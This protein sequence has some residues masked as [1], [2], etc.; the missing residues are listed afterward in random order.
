[1]HNSKSKEKGTSRLGET[2]H[3]IKENKSRQAWRDHNRKHFVGLSWT[4]YSFLPKPVCWIS[5]SKWP[6]SCECMCTNVY[7]NACMCVCIHAC[8]CA[9]MHACVHA[10]VC[11][12]A[13]MNVCAMCSLAGIRP[14]LTPGSLLYFW[15]G[16]DQVKVWILKGE[17][18]HWKCISKLF[19]LLSERY[20]NP[21]KQ[22]QPEKLHPCSDPTNHHPR[23]SFV[24][25]TQNQQGHFKTK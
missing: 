16:W 18:S 20:L 10:Y 25:W 9:R 2:K 6:Q 15:H 19:S 22:L 5:R 24:K 13:R 3:E 8:V 7:V 1:M 4:H 17:N 11:M 12:C 23:N 14:A 21:E